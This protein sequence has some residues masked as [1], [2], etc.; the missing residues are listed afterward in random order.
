MAQITFITGGQRSGKS[1]YAQKMALTLS[2]SPVYLATARRWDQDFEQ[3]IQRHQSDRD[4]RWT[5]LE[6]EKYLSRLA[7]SE[8]VVVIDCIT[9][10]LNN[11]FFDL[12]FDI[13]KA[14]EQAKAEW[15]NLISQECTLIV[16]SNELGMGMHAETET[17]RKFADLQGWMNQYIA[18]GAQKVILMVSGIPLTIYSEVK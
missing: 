4:A 17:A 10:W 8:K 7:L 12:N 6:E 16:V 18:S 2:G 1:A 9:L 5:T 11:F 13:E 15:D 3:R 14:L